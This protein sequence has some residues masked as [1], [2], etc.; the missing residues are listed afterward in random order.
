MS[1]GGLLELSELIF[2]L[3]AGGGSGG[4]VGG[5]GGLLELGELLLVVL[6]GGD[7]MH[8][9]IDDA[10]SNLFGIY[11]ADTVGDELERL[12]TFNEEHRRLYVRQWQLATVFRGANLNHLDLRGCDGVTDGGSPERSYAR[13]RSWS[14]RSRSARSPTTFNL[15]ENANFKITHTQPGV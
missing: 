6:A 12:E 4:G 13:R 2:V 1:G 8:E 10:L 14:T 5:V 3:I 15:S 7:A 9:V 11:V